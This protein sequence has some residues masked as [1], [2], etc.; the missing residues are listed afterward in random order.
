MTSALELLRC[1]ESSLPGFPPTRSKV[2]VL[3]FEA[4]WDNYVLLTIPVRRGLSHH[5]ESP[6][7]QNVVGE[8]GS[9]IQYGF[10]DVCG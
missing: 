10:N 6:S 9:E 2:E 7:A 1:R 3:C 4:N 8:T 5:T